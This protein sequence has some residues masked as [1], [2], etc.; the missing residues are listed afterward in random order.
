M[1]RSMRYWTNI[2]RNNFNTEGHFLREQYVPDRDR[3][4][5]FADSL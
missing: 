5:D 4:F 3:D 2:V 1:V